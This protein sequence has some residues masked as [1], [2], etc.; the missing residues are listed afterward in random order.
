MSKSVDNPTTSIPGENRVRHWRRGLRPLVWWGI[1][2][3]VLYTY[4]LHQ[5][6]SEQTRLTFSVAM[7]GRPIV[8]GATASLDG[9]SI[10]SGERVSIG[11]HRFSISH[12]KGESFST[13][14]FIWYGEHEF[15]EIALDRLKGTLAIQA[16][17]PVALLS[18]RG[19]EFSLTLTNSSGVTRTVPTDR[20]QIVAEYMHGELRQEIS[21]TQNSVASWRCVPRIGNLQMSCKQTGATFQLVRNDGQ[22]MESGELP[23]I[24]RDL[25]EG[26]YKVM[27][28]HRDARREDAAF[29]ET[30]ITR[31]IEVVFSYGAAIVGSEPSGATVIGGNGNS[32]GVTPLLLTELQPGHLDYTLRHEGYEPERVSF[33]VVANETNHLR[34]ILLSSAYVKA[35]GEARRYL[36]A[37][38][39][40]MALEYCDDALHAKPNDADAVAMQKRATKL[41]SLVRAKMLAKKDDYEGAIKELEST[42]LVLPDD[43]GVKQL[44]LD[45]RK[46]EQDRLERQRAEQSSR[47]RV[48]FD[49]VMA[50]N[51]DFTLFESHELK[52]SKPASVVKSAIMDAL[53]NSQPPF[54]VTDLKPSESDPFVLQVKQEVTG[55]VRQC[56]VVGGQTLPDETQI[57]YE[58]LEF[59]TKETVTPLGTLTSNTPIHPSRIEQMTP[60]LQDRVTEGIRAIAE[61]LQS[62]MR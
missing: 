2:V 16:E 44:L 37:A 15:G 14:F 57:F 38:D 47:A 40:V 10:V 45:Y 18:I 41:K 28:V 52:S 1:L 53:R 54:M 49:A 24:V 12:P 48:M 26:S 35:I 42:L 55:G 22:L 33:D 51:R 6:L 50:Q 56:L 23:A 34:T 8:Y 13:N 4:R 20:Y 61:R 62:A 30:G 31:K 27:A 5:R 36:A 11:Q 58:V 19:P 25:P 9:R 59:A 43:E 60:A 17:T 7:E 32:L 46:Y 29:V 3:L 39:Y 21:V